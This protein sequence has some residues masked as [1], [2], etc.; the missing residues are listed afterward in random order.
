MT[1]H[2]QQSSRK[3]VQVNNPAPVF[4][5]PLDYTPWPFSLKLSEARLKCLAAKNSGRESADE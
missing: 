2:N 1:D 4:T 3:Y 5:V